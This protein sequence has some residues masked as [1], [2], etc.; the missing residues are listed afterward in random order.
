[1]QESLDRWQGAGLKIEPGTR[2]TQVYLTMPG[3]IRV[4]I[5]EEASLT[6]PIAFHHVHYYV[7][8]VAAMQSWYVKNFGAAPGKRAQFDAAD[9][10]GANLTFQKAD[11]EEMPTKGTAL[12]HVGFEV[13][14]LEAFT[15][16]LAAAGVKFDQPYRKMP[17][18]NIASAVL[19]DPSGTSVELTEGLAP[20]R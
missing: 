1:M 11:M 15:R 20:A 13:K 10:P 9:V 12:D 5:L 16:K 2:P 17:G 7:S 4:E 6:V 8:D 19:I 18:L 14:N 3:D